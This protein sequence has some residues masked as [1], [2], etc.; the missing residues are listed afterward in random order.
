M[1]PE[2]IKHRAFDFALSVMRMIDELPKCKSHDAVNY[3]LIKSSI[4]VGANYRAAYKAKSS[5]EFINKLKIVEEKADESEYWL[6]LRK[7]EGTNN[8]ITFKRSYRIE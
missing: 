4:S 2:I 5:P 6:T 7:G 1:S 3:K 8:R